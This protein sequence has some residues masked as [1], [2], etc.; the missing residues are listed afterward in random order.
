[1]SVNLSGRQLRGSEVVDEVARAI[2]SHAID[3]KLL[4][5]E[6]TES[7]LLDATAAEAALARIK[8]L[9][10]GL[11]LDDFGTGYSSLSHLHRFPFDALKIDRSFVHALAAGDRHRDM[12]RAI[13]LLSEALHLGVV[14][15]GIETLEQARTLKALGCSYA[16]GYY[17][18]RPVPAPAATALVEARRTWPLDPT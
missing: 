7:V 17:F 1:M 3:P 5:L 14:A 18:S 11:S 13:L 10:V 16:Q 12:V 2:D 15:E 9:G 6:V 8:A 4:K